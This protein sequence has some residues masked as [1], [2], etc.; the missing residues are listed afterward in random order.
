MNP[1]FFFQKIM[2]GN[3]FLRDGRTDMS[4][5]SSDTICQSPFK[6]AGG[7]K[8]GDI[9]IYLNASARGEINVG[10]NFLFSSIDLNEYK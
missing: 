6:M 1:I 9:F 5:D 7:I 3:I 10:I 2:T 8:H 4:K